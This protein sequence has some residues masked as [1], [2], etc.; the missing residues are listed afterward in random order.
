MAPPPRSSP[1]D[2][3]RSNLPAPP[4]A[5]PAPRPGPEHPAVRPPAAPAPRRRRVGL[6]AEAEA[7]QARTQGGGNGHAPVPAD[8]PCVGTCRCGMPA[9]AH[10]MDGCRQ[11]ACGEHLLNRA[12]R[13]AWPGPYRSEREHT[14]YVRAFWAGVGARCAWC[15]EAAGIEA[16][17]A[18][19]PVPP[20]PSE[21]VERL[22]VLLRSPHDYPSDA[23][24]QTVRQHGGVS[25]VAGLLAGNVHR[26]RPEQA[27]GGRR[28]EVLAGVSVGRP[29]TEALEV[30]DRSGVVWVVRPL[31]VGVVRKR[32]AFA[33]ERAGDDHVAR[34]LPHLVELAGR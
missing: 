23:W 6:A 10:C 34:L 12:S 20:L 14:A 3:R 33:W 22:A 13:L 27:F 24:D 17:A 21:V 5:K 4:A 18:L 2:R 11:P 30:M 25:A 26:R 15:R 16:L 29:G 19:P 32:R 8:L 1:P 31:G 9:T 28:G 7:H